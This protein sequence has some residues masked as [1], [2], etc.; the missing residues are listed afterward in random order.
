[1]CI[2]LLMF[3]VKT[4]YID[5]FIRHAKLRNIKDVTVSSHSSL[6]MIGP[7]ERF[8]SRQ[9][10]KIKA[11][12]IEFVDIERFRYDNLGE[13]MDYYPWDCKGLFEKSRDYMH[14][15]SS[16]VPSVK[17]IITLPYVGIISH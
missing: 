9:V 5:D 1:M 4:K 12:G 15:I 13:M 16:E 3:K 17:P 10:M 7:C 11:P 6:H 14:Y 2:F 8:Y